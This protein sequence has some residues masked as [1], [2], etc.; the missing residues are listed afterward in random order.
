MN[1][2]KMYIHVATCLCPILVSFP[3]YAIPTLN[4]AVL[5]GAIV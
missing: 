1:R 2:H 4:F 3:F 5:Y